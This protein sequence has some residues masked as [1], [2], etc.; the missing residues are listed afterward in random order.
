MRQSVVNRAA[1]VALAVV[2]GLLVLS[3]LLLGRAVD[4]QRV[5][6]ER[7]AE[8]KAL[9]LQLQAASD[10]L[11]NQARAYAVT[12]DRRHLD[13][14]WREI[15]ETKTRD[16]VINRLQQL[17]AEQAELDLVAEAKANSDALVATETRSQRLVLEAGGAAPAEMPPAI[18]EYTLGAAD[19][20]LSGTGKLA[21][22]RRIMFDAKYDADKAVIS[23][24]LVKFQDTLNQRAQQEVNDSAGRIGTMVQLLFGLAVLVPAV[25]GAVLYLLQSKVGRVVVRYTRTLASRDP[26]DLLFRIEPAG[27]RELQELGGAFNDELDRSLNLVRTV[28]GSAQALASSANELSLTSQRVAVRAEQANTGTAEV[29]AAA[30]H[31][32][33]N[34]QTV[35]AGAVQMG[36]SI[37]EIAQNAD[38]AARVGADAVTVAASTNETVAKLGQSSAEIGNVIKVITSIAEQTNLLALNATIEAAR[39]GESGK[40]FAVVASE[41]K[42]LAQGTAQATEEISSR[43]QAIQSDTSAAVEAIRQISDVIE[44]INDYQTAIAGAVEEQTATTSEMSRN[45]T[46][47]ADGSGRIAENISSVTEATQAAVTEIAEAKRAAA[48]LAGMGAQLEALVGGYRY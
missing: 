8:F 12:A 28:A 23:G 9:G 30:N 46:E 15:D 17:G 11:T 35:S 19:R 43:I 34:V 4:Q 25:M 18:A 42:D 2:A 1:A 3:V 39:A 26:N 5:A 20:A 27:S 14:Y 24:P 10:F 38:E 13:A 21:V 44:R 45:V 6:Q 33:A 22:A 36:A 37:R 16:H 31:V 40:G 7:Q 47:A 29:S 41:V 32:S 48:A